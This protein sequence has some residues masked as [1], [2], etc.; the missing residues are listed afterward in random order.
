MN[1]GKIAWLVRG[2]YEEPLNDED[3]WEIVFE[4]PSYYRYAEIKRV[5]FFEIE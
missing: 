2:T 4:E 1:K 3:D 5:V